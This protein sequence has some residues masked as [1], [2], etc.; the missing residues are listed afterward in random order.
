M[1]E[2]ERHTVSRGFQLYARITGSD[3]IKLIPYQE[4]L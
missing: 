1:V 4:Y 2:A 3:G